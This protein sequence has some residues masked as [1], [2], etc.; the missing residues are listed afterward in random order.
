M[1]EETEIS[2]RGVPDSVAGLLTS[3]VDKLTPSQQTLLKFASIVGNTFPVKALSAIMTDETIHL[4]L[5]KV[6]RKL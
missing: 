2:L 5:N 4:Q 3:K 1:S 6:R